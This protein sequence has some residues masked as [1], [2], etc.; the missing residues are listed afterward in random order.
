MQIDQK[1]GWRLAK[2]LGLLFESYFLF[3]FVNVALLVPYPYDW[4]RVLLLIA[5]GLIAGLCAFLSSL[6]MIELSKEKARAK[7]K[8]LTAVPFLMW[9]AITAIICLILFAGPGNP[10]LR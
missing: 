2:W 1:F 8:A 6:G 4:K 3:V 10:L 7:L 5:G 9:G